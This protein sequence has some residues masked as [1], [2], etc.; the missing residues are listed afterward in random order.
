MHLSYSQ[1]K[2]YS[3]CPRLYK[4][5][6]IDGEISLPTK[7]M[8]DGTERHENIY[9][10]I[11]TNI[12]DIKDE[13]LKALLKRIK[14][15]EFIIE[16]KFEIDT[17]NA[18]WVGYI[19]LYSVAGDTIYII[20][21]KSFAEPEDDLQLKLYAYALS[22][23]YPQ[24]EFFVCYFY[25]LGAGYFRKKIYQKEDLDDIEK[26][27]IEK[28]DEIYSDKEFK[29]RPSTYC[30]E[31]PFV[32]R[33]FKNN[34]INVAISIKS[35]QEAQDLTDKIIIADAVLKQAK[36]VL[37]DWLIKNGEEEVSTENGNRAYLSPTIALRFGKK[38][39]QKEKKNAK[40][41]NGD[42]SKGV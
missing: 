11:R 32:N 19:D 39:G 1:L 42:N 33:C 12:D 23:E 13:N 30:G 24:V 26:L 31:C 9:K 20:D 14:G 28:A 6:Y 21:F 2:T 22:R 10:L 17:L 3:I 16:K 4:Y 29:E 41:Y 8:L 15:Q 36:D 18:G 40:K 25:M 37:K 34:P 27:L 35:P 7:K 5:K 38:K